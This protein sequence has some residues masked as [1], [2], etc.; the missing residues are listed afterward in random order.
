M[1]IYEGASLYFIFLEWNILIFL[2]VLKSK[3]GEHEI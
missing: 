1:L 3:E 2:A